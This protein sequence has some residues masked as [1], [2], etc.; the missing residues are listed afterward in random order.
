MVTY[1]MRGGKLVPKHQATPLHNKDEATH[2]ISDVMDHLLNHAD[3]KHY[4][5]K[6]EFRKATRRAGYIE[7]GNETTTLLKPRKPIELDRRQRR[8][9]IQ[10]AIYQLKNR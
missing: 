5:S 4:D 9:D 3:C 2:V 8:E 7:Y 6:S 10:R 1:V